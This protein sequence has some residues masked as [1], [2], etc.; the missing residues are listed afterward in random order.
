MPLEVHPIISEDD[1]V[2]FVQI[3]M[4]AFAGGGGITAILTPSPMPDD[5]VQKT[6]N[7]HVKS[8]RDE[9]DITYLKVID[10]DLGGKMIAGA[11]WRINEKG[12]TQEEVEKTLPVGLRSNIGKFQFLYAKK[13]PGA[14]KR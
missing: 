6:I 7:R 4:A 14:R 1:L 3:Q 10:T 11:K 5:Y 9:P 2:T 12:R 13:C 8:W